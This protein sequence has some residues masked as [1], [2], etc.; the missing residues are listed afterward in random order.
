MLTICT[1]NQLKY[2]YVLADSGFSS[3]DNMSFVHLSLNK[4]FIFS[5]KSNRIT[6]FGD[7]ASSLN[8]VLPTSAA[9]KYTGGFPIHKY[10][11]LVT[12][13][14]SNKD[15]M[16]PLAAVALRISRLERM[17]AHA[18]SADIRPQKFFS[19]ETFDLT[20]TENA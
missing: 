3:S 1:D 8:H 19:E 2:R 13:Q 9:A 10:M 16:R 7:K 15:A 18:Q 5:L 20:G 11:K 14:R 12:W 4:H 17:E 6:A